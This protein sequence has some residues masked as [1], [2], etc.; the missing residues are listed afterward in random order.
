[1]HA[2]FSK[3]KVIHHLSIGVRERKTEEDLVS[4]IGEGIPEAESV[5]VPLFLSR[6][7]S[8]RGSLLVLFNIRIILAF[9]LI[10]LI[11]S[12]LSGPVIPEVLDP[13][14]FMK[15]CLF[16][17]ILLFIP[18]LTHHANLH[19]SCEEC[20]GLCE[21]DY[22][23]CYFLIPIDILNTEVEPLGM[24]SCVRVYCH[25]EIILIV[26]YYFGKLKVPA[27][28]V[29]IENEILVFAR[30]LT[31]PPKL[32]FF[33]GLSIFFS[34]NRSTIEEVLKFITH[35]AHFWLSHYFHQFGILLLS[36]LCNV[37]QS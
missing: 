10:V 14:S 34:Y 22:V 18:H 9:T 35:S 28:K 8:S 30:F 17:P 29:R 11:L 16:T 33:L 31:L 21:I 1:L 26:L 12:H 4:C 13:M 20:P 19:A 3:N 27:F 37:V 5:I 36:T 7:G 23:K 32:D 6:W 2:L 15:P 25:L 24:P